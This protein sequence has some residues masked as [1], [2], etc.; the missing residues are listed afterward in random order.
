MTDGETVHYAASQELAGL[1]LQVVRASW[2]H[3]TTARIEQRLIDVRHTRPLARSV[4]RQ[5]LAH[6]RRLLT[7]LV[8]AQVVPFSSHFQMRP[9]GVSI[10]FP[11]IL[12][13]V[14]DQ[15]LVVDGMHRIMAAAAMGLEQIVATV[16]SSPTLPPP[17]VSPCA[18]PEVK[19]VDTKQAREEKF[20][21][22]DADLFRPTAKVLDGLRDL[23]PSTAAAVEAIRRDCR[24]TTAR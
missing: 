18:W 15:L 21:G 9:A 3:Y 4:N 22:F 1:D 17:T 7:D 23:H 6:A 5:R 16:V 24:T 8:E 19:V 11:P 20:P 13:Q 14:D 10:C 12:E 2:P